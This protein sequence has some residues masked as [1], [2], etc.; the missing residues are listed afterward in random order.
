MRYMCLWRP[1]KHASPP[2]EKMFQEMGQLIGEMTA[3]G[4][5][6]LTGGWDLNSPAT[7]LR[8]SAQG[9]VT[10]TDGPYAESKE[11]VGGFAII[12]VPNKDEAIA[13]TKRFVAV[14]GE[15]LSEM[16]PLEH[17]QQR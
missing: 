7:L 15:G 12:D 5:L 17:P 6:V 2:T 8:A 10:V 1:G 11:A 14:A 9:A 13:W 3:K 4:V 16:R